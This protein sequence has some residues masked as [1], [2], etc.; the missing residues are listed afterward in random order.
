MQ[1]ARARGDEEGKQPALQ[2]GEVWLGCKA[3][4]GRDGATGHG[5]EES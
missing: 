3:R 5:G 1:G 4:R 2:V